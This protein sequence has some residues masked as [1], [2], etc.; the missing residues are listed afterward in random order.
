MLLYRQSKYCCIGKVNTTIRD[1]I[2]ISL[3][4]APDTNTI[5]KIH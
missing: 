3:D 4:S 5:A 1:D 2:T